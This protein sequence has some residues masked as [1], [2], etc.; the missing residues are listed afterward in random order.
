[1][2]RGKHKQKKRMR[3][4]KL[5]SKGVYSGTATQFGVL[6]KEIKEKQ[7]GEQQMPLPI[8]FLECPICHSQG[9][10]AR[11][12]CADEPSLPKGIFVSLEKVFTPIQDINKIA[13]PVVKGI[14]VHYDVCVE[15]GTRYC[16]KAE[17]ISA[18]VTAGPQPGMT[19]KNIKA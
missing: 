13:T 9:T 7:G 6:N 16:T 14:L 17:I 4:Q 8:E 1:M 3:R 12:A 2:G 5:A 15:C 19:I 18:P 10:V 11:I